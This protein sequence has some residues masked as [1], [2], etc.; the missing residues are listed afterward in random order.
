MTDYC[1]Y[2]HQGENGESRKSPNAFQLMLQDEEQKSPLKLK[3]VLHSFPLKAEGRY[4]WR[5][6]QQQAEHVFWWVDVSDPNQVL[7]MY[8]GVIFAKLLNLDKLPCLSATKMRVNSRVAREMQVAAAAS[9]A[10]KGGGGGGSVKSTN[11]VFKGREDRNPQNQQQSQQQAQQQRQQELFLKIKQKKEAAA[12]EE[13]ERRKNETRVEKLQRE[14]KEKESS[15]KR[16]WDD[17]DQ[18]WVVQEPVQ[19]P[20]RSRSVSPHPQ[21][22]VKQPQKVDLMDDLLGGGPPTTSIDNNNDDD[23]PGNG[24]VGI[25]LDASNAEGKSE[26]VAAA[27]KGRVDDMKRKQEQAISQLRENE[28][29][30]EKD[31]ADLDSVRARLEP[32][33][34]LWAEEFGKK[35]AIRAL[36]SSLDKVLWEGSG[37]KTVNLGDILEAKRCRLVY[38]KATLKVHPDKTLHYEPEKRFIASRI[39]DALSQAMT[40][41]EDK[42]GL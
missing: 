4:H 33:M 8:Q 22:Q 32:K 18:R 12:R 38:K 24:H 13:A 1:F 15:Q 31:A 9:G 3:H 30:K 37:W 26:S 35:R 10:A 16:V 6:R 5:F 42:G 34:K 40:E 11:R 29:K 27:I 39:F 2:F 23:N 41:F 28:N 25:S 36:L 7:P 19:R 21:S 20:N 14:H 17:V